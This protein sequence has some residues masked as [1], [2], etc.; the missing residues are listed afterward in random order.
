MRIKESSKK[1]LTA[2]NKQSFPH[3]VDEKKPAN[4]FAKFFMT[5]VDGIHIE[6]DSIRIPVIKTHGNISLSVEQRLESFCPLTE[7]DVL[8]LIQKL[9]KKSCM[10]DPIPTSIVTECLD[11]L[12]SEI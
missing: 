1:L 6:I 10:L 12:L 11:V 7:G 3:Y 5:K 8:V 4:E 9:S 2:G